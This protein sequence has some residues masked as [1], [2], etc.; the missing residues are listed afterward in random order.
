[1]LSSQR[2]VPESPEVAVRLDQVSKCFKLRIQKPFLVHD[3]V[4]RMAGTHTHH[5]VFWALRDISFTIRKGESVGIIGA[6]GSGKSTLLSVV[7][8]AIT[9]N[10][11]QVEVGGRMGALLE[12]GA[13]FHPDLTG[14]ENIYLNASLLG[15]S[16]AEI[17]AQFFDILDF[18]E[19]HDFIDAPLRTYSSGMHVRLGFSVAIHIHPDILI[20]DEAL[21]VGDAHFQE[22]CLD[23]IQSLH[24]AGKTLLFVSHSGT[25]VAYLCRRALW[26][27][28]GCLRGDGPCDAILN[29]YQEA[30]T[31]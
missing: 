25:Q 22:K 12:L 18:S 7:A 20:M 29:A 13:G 9:P 8:G 5:D 21:S 28:H 23:R 30:L 14:R 24:S 26:L 15:L 16:K 1:M 4:K 27:D 31:A 11:G 3:V 10:K 2:H 17:E 19:L 6:N